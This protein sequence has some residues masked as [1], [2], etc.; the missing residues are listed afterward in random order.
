LTDLDDKKKS[1]LLV[2]DDDSGTHNLIDYHLEGAIDTI[3]HSMDGVSGI[4]R[5]I[6]ERPDVILLDIS[7]PEM[8][9]Y[10]V[11]R[12]LK[13]QEETRDI[14]IIFLTSSESTSKL[15]VALDSGGT[16]CITKPFEAI[17]LQARVRA[18]L[19][20]KRVIDLLKE[21]ANL[22]S[23]TALGNRKALELALEKILN[24]ISD[25]A[26]CCTLLILNVDF[27]GKINEK[28]GFYSGDN[29]VIKFADVLSRDKSL[30]GVFR[31]A[32]NTFAALFECIGLDHAIGISENLLK[33]LRSS[34]VKFDKIEVPLIC[35][36]G[37][38]T[39]KGINRN[40]LCDE[41]I[42][43]SFEVLR[44]SKSKK[45]GQV[46]GNYYHGA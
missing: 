43:Q 35:T 44:K 6:A 5:A 28:F 16:D 19:R 33:I 27:L 4:V 15:V 39:I 46:I 31:F 9:G 17:E 40:V 38:I 34:N 42:R 3:F 12:E 20:T 11:C 8:D 10:H 7:M 24:D 30:S 32:N 2:I 36:G 29:F 13:G 25:S 26:R 14:P 37:F 45:R 22:D 1:S 41:V 23:L 21:K 18:A